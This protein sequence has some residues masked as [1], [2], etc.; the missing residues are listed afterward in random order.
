M[1]KDQ[2]LLK[3]SWVIIKWSANRCSNVWRKPHYIHEWNLPRRKKRDWYLPH[4]KLLLR[5]NIDST[6]ACCLS[7]NPVTLTSCS[8]QSRRMGKKVY[9]NSLISGFFLYICSH[10][11]F[12][13]LPNYLH[14]QQIYW[15]WWALHKGFCNYS[16]RN[17]FLL[18]AKMY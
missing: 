4:D 12:N 6:R 18:I 3:N 9:T 10:F 15:G 8:L 1:I 17:R 2:I 16:F 13:L 14:K 5:S 7:I 11:T